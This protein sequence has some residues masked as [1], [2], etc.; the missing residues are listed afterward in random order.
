MDESNKRQRITSSND[1]GE[2]R[3]TDLPDGLV[4]GISNYLAK[5]SVVLFAIAMNS[6]ST[7]PPT[8]TSKAIVSSTNWKVLDFSDIEKG[9]AAK[10]SDDDID[11]IL[12]GIDAVNNLHI[13]K[14][15][16]CVN[17][18]GSGL[19]VLRSSVAIEQIDMSLVGKHEVP[20]LEPEPLLSEDE[21]IH[22]LDDIIS[23]GRRSSLKQLELPKKWKNI[24]SIYMTEFL[25]RYD[26]YLTL[27]RYY[28]SKCNGIDF[29]LEEGGMAWVCSE[30]GDWYY[31][32]Q[33][34]TCSGCLNFFCPRES[35]RDENGDAYSNWCK[36]CTKEYCKSCSAMTQ[37]NGCDEYFCN[38]CSEMKE[39]EGSRDCGNDLCENCYKKNT[40]SMRINHACSR[41]YGQGK[42]S[43]CL[44]NYGCDFDGCDKVICEDCFLSNDE[45]GGCQ[46]CGKDFCSADC[47]Y[48]SS[49]GG[50]DC[51]TC[52]RIAAAGFRRR[53]QECK[54]RNE[55]LC[56]KMDA[57][58]K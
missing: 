51:S 8:Q 20:L 40:C 47:R 12:R 19:D 52:L 58:E 7:S 46:S 15:A 42:C 4:V 37:C 17:I 32:T 2:V 13:L 9:L 38:G 45:M 6:N 31:G 21:V 22:I 49:R 24:A 26:A 43:S 30:E 16:G 36:K 34:F 18:T 3:I 5:P 39:C 33:N 35:C 14:L 57:E 28:C 54:E 50:E 44:V 27:K 1:N 55:K 11:N 41:Y 53:L 23:R 29:H 56:R 25:E 10:L 48:L